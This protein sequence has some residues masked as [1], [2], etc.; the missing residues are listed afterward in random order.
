MMDRWLSQNKF[1][2]GNERS[3][4]DLSAAHELDQMKF[5]NFDLS[6]WPKVEAW[7]A[8]FIDSNSIQLQ[9]AQSMRKLAV[10]FNS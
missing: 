10:K 6:K 5:M 9:V 2:C 3:I 7:L 8:E 1:L 4:A